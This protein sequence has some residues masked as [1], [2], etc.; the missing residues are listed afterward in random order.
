MDFVPAKVK[1]KPKGIVE[2]LDMI[3]AD[4]PTAIVQQAAQKIKENA[5]VVDRSTSLLLLDAAK[6]F[7]D[8]LF[9]L[10]AKLTHERAEKAAIR[11]ENETLKKRLDESEALCAE[12]NRLRSQLRDANED[13]ETALLLLSEA[14][15]TAE[16]EREQNSRST[17]TVQRLWSAL[18]KKG[19]EAQ[20]MNAS[21]E[22]KDKQIRI[23][24]TKLKAFVKLAKP[25]K[26]VQD[27][28]DS[29]LIERSIEPEAD[30][31]G[32]NTLKKSRIVRT[33]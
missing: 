24:K 19:E 13:R 3:T 7:E 28:D 17:Q 26:P 20:T 27:P 18:E 9:P 8:Q 11:E 1:R 15:E 16:R 10:F 32:H 23:L 33:T 29:L 2:S 30:R 22:D 12:V 21:L 4:S 25:A 31:E 6:R 5:K 14:Q